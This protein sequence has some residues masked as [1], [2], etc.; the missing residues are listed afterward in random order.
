MELP[1]LKPLVFIVTFLGVFSILAMTI[2]TGL[3][4]PSQSYREPTVEEYFEQIDLQ[5]FADTWGY[6]LNETQGYDAGGGWY[7]VL[8]VG[9][10]SPALF[11]GHDIDLW[12]RKANETDLKLGIVHKYS[13]FIF[14]VGHWMDWL[15]SQGISRGGT[16]FEKYLS[17]TELE[18]DWSN[19]TT[20]AYTVICEHFQMKAFFGYNSTLYDNV[21]HAWNH[22]GFY[23]L[24][25]IDFDEMATG[26]NAWNLLG[27]ILFWQL[28]DVHPVL[29]VIIS[30]PFWVSIGWLFASIAIAFIRSLPFT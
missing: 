7:Y 4:V 18:E 11:G 16:G 12:Y 23:V 22:H 2:P 5:A 15:N 13:W 1:P 10:G 20:V 28:P 25:A 26:I 9:S 14:P 21:T 6:T 3:L 24:L 17:A 27:M 8:A 30:I 29:N 19:E